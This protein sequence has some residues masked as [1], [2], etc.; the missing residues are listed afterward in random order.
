[1]VLSCHLIAACFFSWLPS[2]FIQ[3]LA[4]HIGSRCWAH[5]FW[6]L[7]WCPWN[8]GAI[9]LDVGC[10]LF[11]FE[12]VKR[13]GKPPQGGCCLHILCSPAQQI[14]QKCSHICPIFPHVGT[15][16]EPVWDI[17]GTRFEWFSII[18]R[19]LF[20]KFSK[21]S[22]AGSVLLDYAQVS[23]RRSNKTFKTFQNV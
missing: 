15:I 21:I 22:E 4:A 16:L 3:A 18:Y 10:L 23:L 19:C 9:Q 13:G 1:M 14:H 5:Q 12:I 8:L 17:F 7:T 11:C 2:I 20:Y 6:L